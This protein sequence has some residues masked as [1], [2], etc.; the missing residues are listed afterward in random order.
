MHRDLKPAN[1][2]LTS[3]GPRLLDFGIAALVDGTRLTMTG[4]GP[5]T[6]TYMAPEQFGEERV[7]TAADIWAW[8]CCVVCAAHGAS[9]FAATSTGAVIRRIVDTGPDLA[10]LAAVHALDPAL[11][12][13]VA[14]ALTPDPAARPGDG[15]TLLA[16]LTARRPDGAAD[17]RDEITRGWSTL[18]L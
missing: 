14:H 10:A 17:V 11:A 5:G 8:A 6:L 13:V 3:A 18:R 12:A 1:I 15:A 7:G 2:M 16:L 9:P 4:A